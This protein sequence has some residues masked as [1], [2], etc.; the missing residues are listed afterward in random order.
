MKKAFWFLALAAC[1]AFAP[2]VR[3][4]KPL[5]VA[6]A[7]SVQ[8]A[9]EEIAS[10]FT[11]ET[12][13]PVRVSTGSSGKLT[14]QIKAGAPYDL[15]IS[16]DTAYPQALFAE[17]FAS[18][19]PTVY[20]YGALAVWSASGVDVS[21]G[22]SSLRSEKIKRIA[23]ANP[24]TA[25]FGV[26]AVAAL[27]KAGIF[28]QV[29]NRLVFGESIAQVNQF[30]HAQAADAGITA[31]SSLLAAEIAEKGRWTEVDPALYPP[32]A[33]GIVILK[34]GAQNNPQT[35]K[36]LYTFICSAKGKAILKKHGYT[37]P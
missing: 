9:M 10:S 33:Q 28:E 23:V 7:A 35:A 34:F 20:A 3:A 30:V 16:A 32:I 2:E 24:E 26:S 18:G 5:T 27:R 1:A 8:Y 15:F 22:L 25:P 6:V 4:D 13:I 14:A 31:K 12:G 29:K 17:G 11:R 37:T 36:K 21:G 19:P